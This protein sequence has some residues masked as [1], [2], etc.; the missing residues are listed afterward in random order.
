MVSRE[1]ERAAVVWE[2]AARP[3]DQGGHDWHAPGTDGKT[4]QEMREMC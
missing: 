4:D 1:E 2:N 3:P